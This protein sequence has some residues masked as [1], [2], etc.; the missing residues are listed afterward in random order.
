MKTIRLLSAEEQ[1]GEKSNKCVVYD[2]K[3]QVASEH[4]R[5]VV[6]LLEDQANYI[7]WGKEV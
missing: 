6:L 2:E 3:Q 5:L 7:C 1:Q 4:T